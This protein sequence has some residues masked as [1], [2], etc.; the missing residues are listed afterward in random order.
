MLW[1]R[2]KW[3]WYL[4]DDKV[5]VWQLQRFWK[6]LIA[7]NPFC[8]SLLH[9]VHHVIS[10]WFSLQEIRS[11]SLHFLSTLLVIFQSTTSLLLLQDGL[12]LL[13]IKEM[14]PQW[15]LAWKLQP[16]WNTSPS[17]LLLSKP[18]Q[19]RRETHYSSGKVS[20]IEARFLHSGLWSSVT[21][22]NFSPSQAPIL[23]CYRRLLHLFSLWSS[24][25]DPSDIFVVLCV[26]IERTEFVS[27][28]QDADEQV[29]RGSLFVPNSEK[30]GPAKPSVD[31]KLQTACLGV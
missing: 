18:L 16:R 3:L 12:S 22:P 31:R 17:D 4:R 29:K 5:R 1:R 21:F 11:N 30:Y 24:H 13:S 9:K 10:L 2:A 20:L 26:S 15:Q 14:C 8:T 25:K 6:S 28:S 19:G 23:P 7:Q 27:L